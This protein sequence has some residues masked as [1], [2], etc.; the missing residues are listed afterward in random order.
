M[1]RGR[2][3][4][5]TSHPHIGECRSPSAIACRL[6]ADFFGAGARAHSNNLN[7]NNNANLQQAG[8]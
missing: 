8:D 7:R 6:V 5:Q 3:L 1:R 2:G 4:V